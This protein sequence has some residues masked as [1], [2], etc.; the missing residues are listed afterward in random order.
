MTHHAV[1]DV[2]FLDANVLF[3]VTYNPNSDFQKL[4]S[5]PNTRI[6]ASDYVI[7]EVQRNSVRPEQ[8][9]S[10][11]ALL[12]SMDL[13]TVPEIEPKEMQSVILPPKDRPILASAIA[14]GA[15]HLLTGDYRHFRRY[16]ETSIGGVL[17]LTPVTYLERRD[18]Q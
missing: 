17:V 5:M 16:Y 15:T 10:L 7:H 6:L 9:S 1:R 4:W 18:R 11:R 2:V 3:A 14:S 13:A 8:Q 12:S